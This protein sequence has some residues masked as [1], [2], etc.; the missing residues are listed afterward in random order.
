MWNIRK[1]KYPIRTTTRKIILKNEDSVRSFWDNFK[2]TN[3]HMMG[4]PEGEDSK[5]LKTYLKN[6]NRKLP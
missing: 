3:I 2:C 6:N 1:Q 5:K 4:V